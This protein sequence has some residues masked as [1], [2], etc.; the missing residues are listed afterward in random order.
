MLTNYRLQT[1]F[2][3]ILILVNILLQTLMVYYVL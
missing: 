2:K 1:C 3:Y